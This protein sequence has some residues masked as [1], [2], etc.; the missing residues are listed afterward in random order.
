MPSASILSF[1]LSSVSLAILL[2]SLSTT[3][4]AHPQDLSS[5]E[6]ASIGYQNVVYWGQ[7]GG[8][9]NEYE[10]EELSSY[11]GADSGIDIIILAFLFKFGNGN[12]IPSGAFGRECWVNDNGEGVN[13]AGLIEGIQTCKA[14]GV[15]ILVSIGGAGGDN[16]AYGLAN[17]EEAETIGQY[18]W[19]AYGLESTNS[20]VPRPFDNIAIDGWD[21]NPE[22]GVGIEFYPT[23][24]NKLRSNFGSGSYLITGAPMCEDPNMR[25]VISGAQFDYVWV[26]FYNN[27]VC[28]D[29]TA[30]SNYNDWKDFLANTGYSKSAKIFIGL[31]ADQT[32]A[33]VNA[34][35]SQFYRDPTA[36]VQLIDQ[37]ITDSAFGGT[38]LWNA[39][40]SGSNMIGNCN[41]A[42]G[43][44]YVLKGKPDCADSFTTAAAP[45]SVAQVPLSN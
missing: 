25:S 37:F 24:I 31:P 12:T 3:A 7:N 28:F 32:A 18:L 16:S 38:A 9:A 26:Q 20:I 13:C 23:L 29:A 19:E 17:A 41:Y 40:S 43:T 10:D 45:Q 2:T 14:A 15:K 42:Q 36:L 30:K 33:S 8:N 6:A 35:S 34:D 27:G 11:C 39:G 44:S 22:N 5:R 1:I 4:S 21:F